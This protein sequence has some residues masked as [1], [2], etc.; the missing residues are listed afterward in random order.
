MIDTYYLSIIIYLPIT[1]LSVTYLLSM[2]KDL[3]NIITTL[4]WNK[5]FSYNY[6]YP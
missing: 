1:H 4:Y 2:I 3:Q 6:S 5:K